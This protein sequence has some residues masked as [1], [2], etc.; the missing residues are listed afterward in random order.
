MARVGARTRRFI[1][2]VGEEQQA[3]NQQI[4]QQLVAVPL[5]ERAAVLFDLIEQERQLPDHK[6]IAFFSTAR[7][8]GFMSML[9]Q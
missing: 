7:E 1:D 4:A 2:C 9:Y 6:I 8:T 3:T 5:E